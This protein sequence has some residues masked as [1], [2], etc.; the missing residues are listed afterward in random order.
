[1]QFVTESYD[2]PLKVLIVSSKQNEFVSLL[3]NK[4]AAFHVQV[5]SKIHSGLDYSQYDV[6]FFIDTNQVLPTEFV[7][8]KDKKIV[9]LFFNNKNLAQSYSS[10]AYENK[11]NFIKVI[12]LESSPEFYKKD[13]E[14]IL[15]FAF[16][17]T[18][19]LY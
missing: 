1:M 2:S 11:L 10:Y 8:Y 14:T 3:K 6:C 15:W 7:D 9:F 16:S 18:E 12:L 17:R 4:M 5:A 13:I 19:D